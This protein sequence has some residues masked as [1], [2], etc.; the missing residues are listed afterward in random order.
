MADEQTLVYAAGSASEEELRLAIG[1][2]FEEIDSD[3]QIREN[4]DRAGVDL[5][6]VRETGADAVKVSSESGKFGGVEAILFEIAFYAGTKVFEEVILP[7][8]KKRLSKDAVGERQ[9]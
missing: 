8:I 1:E 6:T 5:A 9:R 2:F 4:A 3:P 7:W